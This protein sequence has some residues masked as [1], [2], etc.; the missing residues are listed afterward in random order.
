MSNTKISI[1]AIV[2]C[3]ERGQLV[4]PKDLRK[5][6]GIAA[7]DKLAIIKCSN[8]DD[9]YC[10]TIIKSNSLEHLVVNYL[11]PMLKDIVK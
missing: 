5:T 8:G 10:L 7:G 3:D 2:S 1:E 9:D 11:G 4:L 6:L